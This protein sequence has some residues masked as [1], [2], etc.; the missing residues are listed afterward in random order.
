MAPN[1]GK[2]SRAIV[3]GSDAL[4]VIDTLKYLGVEDIL[5]VGN[6]PELLAVI[7]TAY[8]VAPSVGNEPGVR[9]WQGDFT[10]LPAYQGPAQLV[11]FTDES[12]GTEHT[13]REALVKACLSVVAGGS[14]II[15]SDQE[16]RRWQP[17]YPPT[18]DHLAAL[19]AGLPLN[20][21]SEQEVATGYC[22][23]L[24][25]PPGYRLRAPVML[26]GTVV[27]GFGRGSRQMGTPTA[28]IDTAGL[29][30][31]LK[32][33]APGVYFGWAKVH[34]PEGWPSEDSEVHKV[35]L[36]IGSRPTVNTGNEAPSVEAHILH[37]FLGG[38][39]F[40]GSKLEVLALGFLRP[41]IRFSGVE[42]LVGRIRSDIALA[43]GALDAPVMVAQAML[44]E[45]RSD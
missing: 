42:A 12:F 2:H 24:Q 29:Q 9:V 8:G 32:D 40:Y 7:K 19:V 23:I 35:V 6:D 34:A 21:H 17:K 13:P 33:L 36:N 15:H 18:R 28:N 27:K 16:S 20:I 22:G 10:E 25:V 5:A 4:P 38:Q 11:V 43:R 41:E 37:T 1:V 26:S 45:E 14:V 31:A 30:R 44:L 39:E 3:I